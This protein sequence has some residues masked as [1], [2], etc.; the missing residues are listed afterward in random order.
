MHGGVWLS[1]LVRRLFQSFSYCEDTKIV[2]IH[3][4]KLLSCRRVR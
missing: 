1:I 4:C 3:F 2:L